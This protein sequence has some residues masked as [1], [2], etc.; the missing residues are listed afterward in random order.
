[1]T[2]NDTTTETA[3]SRG[4]ILS[5]FARLFEFIPNDVIAL[6]ARIIVGLV[7]WKSGQTKVEGFE[8]KAKTF[9]LFK[10]IYKVPFVPPDI[11]AYMATIAE[12]VFPVL[13]WLGLATRISAA[14][15]LIMTLVIQTFVFPN[16]Y[17]THGLWAVAL[18]YLMTHGAGVISLDHLFF[19]SRESGTQ[20]T[21]VSNT[22]IIG[23]FLLLVAVFI[24]WINVYGQAP[25]LK[26][27]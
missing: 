11:A 9:A 18:L 22:V 1:M 17:V 2:S 10:D 13:L 8:I 7:F 16:A 19:G 21:A 6:L 25:S 3:E 5:P 26:G 14:A 15:L 24:F 4:S 12:H 27:V 23:L 20:S